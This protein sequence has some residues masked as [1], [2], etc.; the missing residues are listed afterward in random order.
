[1][2]GGS[3]QRRSAGVW[4]DALARARTTD[5][6]PTASEPVTGPPPAVRWSRRKP[7]AAERLDR[8]RAGLAA[9]SERVSVPTENLLTPDLVRRLVWDWQPVTDPATVIDAFLAEAGARP[10]QRELMVPVLTEALTAAPTPPA[11]DTP[12]GEDAPTP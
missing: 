10:W 12:P 1:M 11:E 3:R 6:V 7:E 4:L 5:D 8:V 2:F 9:L